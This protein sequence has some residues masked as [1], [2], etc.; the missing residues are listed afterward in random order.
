MVSPLTAWNTA[1]LRIRSLPIELPTHW[2]GERQA[3]PVTEA[4]E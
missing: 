1:K 4:A 3:A 2:M